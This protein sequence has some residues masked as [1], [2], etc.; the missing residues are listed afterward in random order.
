MNV[1]IGI[2]VGLASSRVLACCGRLGECRACGLA[3]RASVLAERQAARGLDEEEADVSDANANA[4]SKRG[5]SFEGRVVDVCV[6]F[7]CEVEDPPRVVVE[8]D[9]RVVPRHRWVEDLESSPFDVPSDGSVRTEPIGFSPQVDESG[10][11][12]FVRPLEPDLFSRE[13]GARQ[14]VDARRAQRADFRQRLPADRTRH[15]R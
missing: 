14:L 8:R 13:D 1:T 11:G 2:Q 9:P 10:V 12:Y 15:D 6:V 4:S 3:R 5:G 7:G